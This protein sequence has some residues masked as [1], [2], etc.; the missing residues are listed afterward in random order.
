[1][2]AAGLASPVRYRVTGMDCSACATKMEGA[3]RKVRGVEEV[4]VSIASQEM[5]LRLKGEATPLPELE[6]TI[7]EL[8]YRLTRLEEQGHGEEVP[9]LSHVTPA[10]K[11]A[12]WIVILLNAGYGLVEIVGGFLAGSQSVKADAL[13]FIGDGLISLLGLIAIGWGL[14]ARATAALLQGIFLGVLG[15]G[16]LGMTA[17]RVFFL[18]QPEA[19][20]MGIFGAVGLAVNIAAAA[21]LLPH[22]HGDANVRAIWL[23]SRNDAIGNVAVVIAAALVAWTQTP[24]PDLL[25]A[26]VIAGLFLQSASSI[27]KDA[28]LDLRTAERSVRRMVES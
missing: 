3:A 4:R 23:F 25:V 22:R 11:R 15:V 27:I 1:M 20:L 12:L 21:A 28:R 2:T 9:D 16:V 19:Q 14:A 18:Q 26:V 17:Y 24:W 7:T 6:R 8:G 10:Y 13:D 5:T